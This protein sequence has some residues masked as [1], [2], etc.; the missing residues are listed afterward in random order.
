MLWALLSAYALIFGAAISAQLEAVREGDPRPQDQ[1]K[2]AES[3]PAAHDG[4]RVAAGV[5]R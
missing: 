3:E 1:E 4:D 5:A 2:V